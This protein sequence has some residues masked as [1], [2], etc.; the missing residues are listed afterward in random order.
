MICAGLLSCLLYFL[1]IR[2]DC[3]ATF[4]KQF[5]KTVLLATLGCQGCPS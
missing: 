5:L 2:M 4:R 1:L 3:S